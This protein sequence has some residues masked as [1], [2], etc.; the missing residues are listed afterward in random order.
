MNKFEDL[1][2]APNVLKVLPVL[3]YET[4][5]PIQVKSIPVI[6]EGGDLLAQ[7]QTGTGK[8]AAFA[9]P[10]LS[11]LDLKQK[12][13]QALVLTPTR[14]LAIQVAEA[15]HDY[16]K[17]CEGFHVLPIY[18]GQDYTPQLKALKR[19]VHVVVGTPGR[20]MDHLRRGNLVLS[21]LK[22]IV[23]D[24]ADEMLK[25][26]FVEDIKWILEQV[27]AEHQT[28]LFS[29]TIPNT[30]RHIADQYLNNPT[31]IQIKAT[32]T[33]LSSIEQ[34]YTIVSKENKLEALTRF[35]EIEDF[36]A[37]IIFTRTKI[38]SVELAE[39][40]EAR[41]HSVA[42]INGDMTQKI[43]ERVIHNLKQGN[44]DIIVATEVA[45]RGLDIERISFVVSY[46]IPYDVDS[47]THRIGRT[48]RAGRTGKALVLVTPR[49][50]RM[51]KDIQRVTK[52]TITEITPPSGIQVEEKQFKK[53]SDNIAQIILQ[54]DLSIYRDFIK[55]SLKESSLTELDIAAALIFQA[56]KKNKPKDPKGAEPASRDKPPY[57]SER[58][59][60][61]GSDRSDS[62][63]GDSRGD[64]GGRSNRSDRSNSE[65]PA[66]SKPPAQ[67]KPWRK[68]P[69]V[70]TKS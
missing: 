68:K 54:E 17:F 18:G 57:R 3:G 29:A 6:L 35:L 47:Y 63:S 53:L 64:R 19:G 22:T 24:E 7:A 59:E 15:F 33:A 51:L 38:E 12:Q 8:T 1:G 16:A 26:G 65:R 14:E 50:Y 67:G 70:T 27:P 55:A 61:R 13:P 58:S 21:Q 5:T 46:D 11:M 37:A 30:I 56:Q 4:A 66:S 36:T 28:A 49:E 2:L 39:R 43:R 25:M 62:R 9:L 31:T 45:A 41:G 34:F 52:Q 32:E 23:L 44:I 40:L 10:I 60:R 42:A 20:I 48:G 69:T